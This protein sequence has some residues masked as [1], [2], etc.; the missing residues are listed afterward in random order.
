MLCEINQTEKGKQC[1]FSLIHKNLDLKKNKTWKVEA[2][3]TIWGEEGYQRGTGRRDRESNVAWLWWKL[4]VF[5]DE[6]CHAKKYDL[7]Q[8]LQANK[9]VKKYKATKWSWRENEWAEITKQIPLQ[10]ISSCP[11]HK[12]VNFGSSLMIM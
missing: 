5:R 7:V 9:V 10:S 1:M 11:C 3:R 8:W 4:M 12:P 6:K 2:V